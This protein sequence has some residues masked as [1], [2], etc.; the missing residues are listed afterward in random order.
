MAT[1][2]SARAVVTGGSLEVGS[3]LRRIRFPGHEPQ[4]ARVRGVAG[5]RSLPFGK[6]RRSDGTIDGGSGHREGDG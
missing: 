5:D 6:R 4:Y 1:G 2:S 3:S